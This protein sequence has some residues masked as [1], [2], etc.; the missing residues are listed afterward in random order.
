MQEWP[1]V[2]I[3]TDGSYKG[4]SRCGGYAAVMVCGPYQQIVYGAEANTT[5]N[6][7]ELS[8]VL[9]A[10]NR[11]NTR[12]KVTVI[13]DSEYVVKGMTQYIGNWVRNNWRN[14]N[15]VLI[16]NQD[17]WRQIYEHCQY[18]SITGHWVKGHANDETNNLCDWFAQNACDLIG[19][20]TPAAE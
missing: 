2:H 17:L 15:R 7:M 10:L 9:C 16:M 12:C 4:A 14:A 20:P 3:Y 18:H 11:L 19:R 1:V 8:A 13:S 6:R 5:N